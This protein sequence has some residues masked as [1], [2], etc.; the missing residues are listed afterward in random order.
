MIVN[1]MLNGD[2]SV[3]LRH[4]GA[5]VLTIGRL[6]FGIVFNFTTSIQMFTLF[7]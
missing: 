6:K 5:V 4:Q 2:R 7:Y 3:I 1:G